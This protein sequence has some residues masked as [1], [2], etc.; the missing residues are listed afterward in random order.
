MTTLRDTL[1]SSSNNPALGSTPQS[2]PSKYPQHPL[3]VLP[4]LP[5]SP[6]RTQMNAHSSNPNTDLFNGASDAISSP[7]EITSFAQ[8]EPIQPCRH[9][10]PSPTRSRRGRKRKQIS[11]T[12]LND[13][14]A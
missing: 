14:V 4:V 8:T 10:S 11:P 6:P 1:T 2:S 12:R 3:H 7:P 5:S 13:G 9:Q